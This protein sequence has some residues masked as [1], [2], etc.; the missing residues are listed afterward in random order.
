LARFASG[1]IQILLGTQMLAKGLD[2]PNV[3]LVGVISADT[4]LSLPDFRA[5]ERTFQLLTQVAG[6][7]GRGNDPGNVIIQTFLPE[8]ETIRASI[9]QDYIAFATRELEQRKSVDLPPFARQVRIILRDEDPAKL[10]MRSEQLSLE[11]HELIGITGLPVT[12]KGPMPAPVGRIAGYHR[13]QIVLVASRAVELQKLLARMR[14][15]KKLISSDRVAIDVDPV[16][17]L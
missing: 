1:E 12:L 16:A 17:L 6:R 10:S 2:F 9:S 3:T 11:L 7:A 5:A 15:E 8:D 14:G 4:A 13:M